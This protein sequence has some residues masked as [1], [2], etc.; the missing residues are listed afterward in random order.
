M[1]NILLAQIR[2]LMSYA[3]DEQL[4]GHARWAALYGIDRVGQNVQA[5][6]RTFLETGDER[7]R[8]AAY[9]AVV[10]R[11]EMT[12]DRGICSAAEWASSEIGTPLIRVGHVQ[13]RVA[14][15]L[16]SYIQDGATTFLQDALDDLESRTERK[17]SL[18]LITFRFEEG[19]F[20]VFCAANPVRARELFEKLE[21]PPV[22]CSIVGDEVRGTWSESGDELKRLHDFQSEIVRWNYVVETSVG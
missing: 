19:R 16:A 22:G 18:E 14:S 15:A 20:R 9:L 1:S 10:G 7:I 4:D 11:G 5:V 6:V 12:V 13:S 2:E 21:N 17:S 8:H 3:T